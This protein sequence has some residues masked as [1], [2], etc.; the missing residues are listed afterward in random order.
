MSDYERRKALLQSCRQKKTVSIN[1]N[2]R[3]EELST[4]ESSGRSSFKLRLVLSI[5]CFVC[6]CS[7][8]YGKMLPKQLSEKKIMQEITRE[9]N[10]TEIKLW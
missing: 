4:P 8:D 9:I 10:I 2:L 5:L 6:Y 3:H 7:M 1:Q